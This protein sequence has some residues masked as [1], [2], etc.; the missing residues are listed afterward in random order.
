MTTRQ[1]VAMK[2]KMEIGVEIGAEMRE[3]SKRER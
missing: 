3:A 1:K 2:E